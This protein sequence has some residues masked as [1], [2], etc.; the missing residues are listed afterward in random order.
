MQYTREATDIGPRPIG[1][2]GHKK[3]EAL[4]RSKLKGDNLEEDTFTAQT[5]A[6]PFRMTNFIAK[7]PG[8]RPGVIV[9]CG[10]YDTLYSL[11]NFVGANDGGSSTGLLLELADVLRGKTHEGPSIWL[12]WFDGEEAVKNWTATDS[13]Y[14]SRHLAEKWQQDGTI[15]KIK[16]LILLDMIGDADLNIEHDSN[17][18]S[19]LEDMLYQSATK[20]GYESRF[21]AYDNTIDDDHMP[22]V[23]L[24]VP[25]VDIIDLHY[26]PWHTTKDTLDKLSPKS[27][28]VTGNTTLQLVWML[29][30]KS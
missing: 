16:A 18:T 17:S 25:S 11:K 2:A 1:S 6:G 15:P 26:P 5:P 4:L 8:T 28:E 19:W 30:A 12:V 3:I 23:K 14:G 24:G 29:S 20:L 21:F 22:F 13:V 27:L 9:L 10:H 7:Y